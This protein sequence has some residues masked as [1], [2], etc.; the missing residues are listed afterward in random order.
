MLN[1]VNRPTTPETYTAQLEAQV[2]ARFKP[3]DLTIVL[4]IP[5]RFVEPLRNVVVNEGSSVELSGLVDVNERPQPPAIRWSK[6]GRA[7]REGS[8]DFE[9][10]Y[11]DGRVSLT[12]PEAYEPDG[13]TYTCRVQN[14]AGSV[15][16]SA[17]L[18]VRVQSMP[19]TFSE[20][21]HDQRVQEGEPMRFVVRVG[22]HPPPAVTWYRE[23]QALVSSP[24]FVIEQQGDVHT[25]RIPEVFA[26]DAGRYSV[27]AQNA[28]GEAVCD[29]SL[30]VD[31]DDNAPPCITRPLQDVA[32]FDGQPIVLE[33]TVQAQP[34]VTQVVWSFNDAPLEQS[35]DWSMTFVDG[36]ARLVINE[37]FVDDQGSYSCTMSNS[38]GQRS[39]SAFVRVDEPP[40]EPVLAPLSVSTAEAAPL[41][42]PF[43]VSKFESRLRNAPNEG[44]SLPAPA[45]VD[46]LLDWRAKETQPLDLRCS[47]R[48]SSACSVH[49]YLNGKQIRPSSTHSLS[50]EPTA[51]GLLECKLHIQSL[52]T[53]DNGWYTVCIA[54]AGGRDVCSA[55]LAVEAVP[56]IDSS[57]FVSP[58]TLSQLEKLRAEPNREQTEAGIV[59]KHL[60]PSFKSTPSDTQVFESQVVRFDCTVNGRPIPELTWLLNGRQVYEDDKHKVR[61]HFSLPLQ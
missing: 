17:Q 48:S 40:D 31:T 28:A 30:L 46:R 61:F 13:G 20:A 49:W 38:V 15:E 58:G 47:A 52:Q 43:E 39:T 11:A 42:E 37:A 25:L 36:L 50:T 33:C 21:L 60:K 7:I 23:A 5:P 29:A 45:F 4:P 57:S 34:P 32:V 51:N 54:N 24:D 56:V 27:R 14:E 55:R 8:A 10:R 35:P 2:Q 12:I 44:S 22:G 19:P 6:N 26:E 59:E 9:L 53:T 3:V 18:I 41:D 16:S 1:F